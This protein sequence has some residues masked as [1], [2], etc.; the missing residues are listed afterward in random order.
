MPKYYILVHYKNEEGK[1][2]ASWDT[3][4]KIPG[5]MH[6]N[7][8]GLY[9]NTNAHDDTCFGISKWW[10]S[11]GLTPWQGLQGGS[12][13]LPRK[14]SGLCCGPGWILDYNLCEKI[15]QYACIHDKS[16]FNVLFVSEYRPMLNWYYIWKWQFFRCCKYVAG[17]LWHSS[18]WNFEMKSKEKNQAYEELVVP[19]TI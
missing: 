7:H 18:I 1:V 4:F 19:W 2:D 12:G 10:E 15:W 5:C 14:C 6:P 13:P 3:I 17:L 11:R 16:Y 9:E 8:S